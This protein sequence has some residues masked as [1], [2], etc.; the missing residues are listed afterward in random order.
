MRE[1]KPFEE[2]EEALSLGGIIGQNLP[3]DGQE[4]LPINLDVDGG[5]HRAMNSPPVERLG[6]YLGEPPVNIPPFLSNQVAATQ[7]VFVQF[8]KVS[9]SVCLPPFLE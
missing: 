7:D 3:E 1:G 9:G 4:F 6:L 2:M 8:L 5:Q